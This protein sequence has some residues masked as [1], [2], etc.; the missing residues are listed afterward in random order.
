MLTSPHRYNTAVFA[1][2][3]ANAYDYFVVTEDFL[4]A[5]ATIDKPG[6]MVPYYYDTYGLLNSL[7]AA[8]INGSLTKMNSSACM[9]KYSSTF[10]SDARNV[11]LVS[12]DTNINTTYL[13]ISTWRPDAQ[14]PYA[15]LCGDGWSPSPYDDNEPVCTLAK[16]QAGASNWTLSHHP[17]SFCLVQEVEEECRLQFSIAIMIVVILANATKATVMILTWWKFRTPTLV[18]I[19]DA[20]KSFLDNPDQTTEGV[21]LTTKSDIVKAKGGWKSQGA[22]R[23]VPVRQFWFR[24]ASVKRWL[25][26]NILCGGFIIL[27]IVLLRLGMEG[28]GIYDLKT[29]W[30][31]G[32]GQVNGRAI[33]GVAPSGLIPKILFANLPQGILSFLYL[34]YNSLYSCMLGAHE[35]SLF[36]T[37]RVGARVTS[38][39]G[40]QRSKYYLQLPYRYAVVSN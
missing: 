13:G 20:V 24:A 37:R 31:L 39:L 15:W 26:C 40:N 23:W 27:G 17:I 25:T 19:G 22:K 33:V 6:P 36:A 1:S 28:V 21:C 32:F 10:V 3:T 11:L 16:A 34:T 12:T 38:P 29:L 2:T 30:G 7:H 8:A 35:W 4:A 5:N 18:T 9:S 14:V